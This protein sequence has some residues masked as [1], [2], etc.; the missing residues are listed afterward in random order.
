MLERFVRPQATFF[1]S[2]SSWDAA[3]LVGGDWRR[4][5]RHRLPGLSSLLAD[6]SR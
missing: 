4:T 2:V 5:S 1:S 6:S 3:R